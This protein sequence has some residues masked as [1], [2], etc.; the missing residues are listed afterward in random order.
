MKDEHDNCM[1]DLLDHSPPSIPICARLAGIPNM[2]GLEGY[3]VPVAFAA[4]DW[5]VIPRRIRALLS[6]GRL[7]GRK[8][9]NG[10]WGVLYPYAVTLGR[11]GPVLKR[12]KKLVGKTV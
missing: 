7:A 11:R 9:E 12:Q 1:Q 4:K 10:Y 3:F 6:A 2:E 5:N 8:E